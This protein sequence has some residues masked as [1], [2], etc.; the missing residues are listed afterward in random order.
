MLRFLMTTEHWLYNEASHHQ[1]DENL[2]C[3]ARYKHFQRD[4][5][6]CRNIDRLAEVPTD[7]KRPLGKKVA[8]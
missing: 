5:R 8:Q 4:S 2:L 6:H 3:T 1:Q 7:H